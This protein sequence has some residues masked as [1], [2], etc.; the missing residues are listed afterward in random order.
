LTAAT[1]LATRLGATLLLDSR[2]IFLAPEP[3]TIDGLSNYI[4]VPE[5]FQ[6][7]DIPLRACSA[8]DEATLAI[9]AERCVLLFLN[10]ADVS[11]WKK[12]KAPTKLPRRP[13]LIL[14]AQH[15]LGN[16]LR[17]WGS[18]AAIA[19]ATGRDL[20]VVWTP[21]HHCDCQASD[22]FKFSS[23]VVTRV[24]DL[25]LSQADH[26]TYMEIE[27][28]AAK[29][30][31]LVMHPERDFYI[32][33]AYVLNHPSSTWDSE[34]AF[35]RALRPTR[36]VMEIIESVEADGRLG[37]HVRFEGAHGTD[38]NSYDSAKNWPAEGHEKLLAWREK[39]HPERF[40][41]R[42]DALS[43]TRSD[44]KIFLA[45]DQPATYELFCAL[46]PQRLSFVP[47]PVY[48]RSLGQ[49][50]YALADALLLSRCNHLLGSTWSSF[51]ELARRFSTT[52]ERVEMSGVDF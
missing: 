34:N 52:L 35:I 22:L 30:A 28:G 23:E 18:A 43:S 50:R 19:K 29:D 7:Y 14:D 48:D 25:D 15:G 49:L 39:S 37:V 42:I 9:N 10:P 21:D 40:I 44:L 2:D 33:S 5:D 38:T 8:P 17:A 46:Y 11:G 27:P 3:T 41:A 31:P 51:T 26:A 20:V 32:R 24:E 4:P 16:R 13:R 36:E 45:A 6:T 12:N 1:S 47:R